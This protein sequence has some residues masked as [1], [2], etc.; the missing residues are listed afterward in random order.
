MGCLGPSYGLDGFSKSGEKTTWD[1]Q[2]LVNNGINYQP[3]LVIAG[4]FPSTV[5]FPFK[6]ALFQGQCPV[7]ATRVVPETSL[8]V[9]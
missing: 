4:F 8:S 3:Q 6:S 2:N 5:S 1:V 7:I 9:Y